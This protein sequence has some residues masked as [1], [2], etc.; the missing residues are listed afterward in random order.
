MCNV[1]SLWAWGVFGAGDFR[2]VF[3][4]YG[5]FQA[6][7]FH[8]QILGVSG[9]VF[10]GFLP[11]RNV[12]SIGRGFLPLKIVEATMQPFTD[13]A[14]T[15]IHRRTIPRCGSLVGA[16]DEI[17]NNPF[18]SNVFALQ[19]WLPVHQQK[20]ETRDTS[21]QEHITHNTEITHIVHHI[22]YTHTHHAHRRHTNTWCTF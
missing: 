21:Q 17:L 19:D 9:P 2:D 1:L 13:T 15:Q 12:V 20:P 5:F 16:T 22:S 7:A 10:R 18:P 6:G 11:S 8:P 3:F 14:E 4:G